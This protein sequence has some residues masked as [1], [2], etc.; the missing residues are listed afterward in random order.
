MDYIVKNEQVKMYHEIIEC[1]TEALEARDIYTKGHSERVAHMAKDIA[2]LYGLKP[3][4]IE[5]IHIAG[6]LHDIGKIGIPDIILNKPGKLTNQEYETIKTHCEIGYKILSKS[7]ELKT[8]ADI[9][10]YHHERWDGAG[11]PVGK[12]ATDIPIEARIIAVSDA[13]DAMLTTRTYKTAM[14]IDMCKIEV[15]K[16]SGKQFDP[17]IVKCMS[18]LWDKWKIE[19]KNIVVA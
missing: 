19:K 2:M 1:L 3:E 13:I 18:S 9:I 14:S 7:E 11:Y 12:K 10:L 15:E 8:I 4:Q 16:N 6:H 5:L 17:D